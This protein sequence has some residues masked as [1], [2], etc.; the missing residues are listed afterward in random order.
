[1][2]ENR[3]IEPCVRM[4]GHEIQDFET[5]MIEIGFFARRSGNLRALHVLPLSTINPRIF[6]GDLKVCYHHK[7]KPFYGCL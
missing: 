7:Y 6:G 1:M 4:P 5:H 3:L 2:H